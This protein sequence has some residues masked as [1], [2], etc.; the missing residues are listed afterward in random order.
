[1]SVRNTDQGIEA[2]TTSWF[3][4]IL[5]IIKYKQTLQP[6]FYERN[7]IIWHLLSGDTKGD[8]NI[9]TQLPQPCDMKLKSGGVFERVTRVWTQSEGILASLCIHRN[10]ALLIYD[11]FY[12]ILPRGPGK[13]KT[14]HVPLAVLGYSRENKAIT[15]TVSSFE[16]W[17][18]AASQYLISPK[19]MTILHMLGSMMP[20]WMYPEMS[21]IMFTTKGYR[22]WV[23]VLSSK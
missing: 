15:L 10:S 12:V 19:V 16:S 18:F 13:K 11:G 9:K 22:K 23:W 5:T 7:K 6:T 14:E 21:V 2:A 8:S 4:P 17:R 3:V 1:M 20:P